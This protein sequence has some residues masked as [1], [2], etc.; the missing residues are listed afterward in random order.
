MFRVECLLHFFSSIALDKESETQQ[1]NLNIQCSFINYSQFLSFL[2]SFFPCW[3]LNLCAYYKIKASAL[4]LVICM[5]MPALLVPMIY[6]SPLH[7]ISIPNHFHNGM[8]I[9]LHFFFYPVA[10]NSLFYTQ[11]PT[12]MVVLKRKKLTH[13]WKQIIF[14][15]LFLDLLISLVSSVLSQITVF[16]PPILSLCLC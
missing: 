4:P 8:S 2:P 11:F 5:P 12:T 1:N 13:K 16:P 14:D 15:Y 3:R 9:F 7:L 6:K 10:G